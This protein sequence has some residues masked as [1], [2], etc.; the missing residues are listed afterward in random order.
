V[1]RREFG[2]KQRNI[3]TGASGYWPPNVN[4]ADAQSTPDARGP[5]RTPRS[6]DSSILPV[7]DPSTLPKKNFGKYFMST[8]DKVFRLISAQNRVGKST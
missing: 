1:L 8:F 2:Q 7:L 5:R 6:S 4:R 3:K